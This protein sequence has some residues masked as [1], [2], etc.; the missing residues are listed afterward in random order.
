M[1][2]AT[3]FKPLFT[4]LKV[5]LGIDLDRSN[6]LGSLIRNPRWFIYS[7]I[8]LVCAHIILSSIQ[9]YNIIDEELQK[10]KLS[11]IQK[12]NLVV[13]ILTKI[14]SSILIH[15]CFFGDVFSKW[16]PLRNRLQEINDIIGPENG[17]YRRLRHLSIAVVVL[18]LAVCFILKLETEH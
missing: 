14:V 2:F 17:L 5:L 11:Q 16:T 7:L 10:E 6:S 12:F 4:W 3:S 18:L 15:I 1:D 9:C 13:H 8:L